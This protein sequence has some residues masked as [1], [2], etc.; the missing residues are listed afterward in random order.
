MYALFVLHIHVISVQL[1]YGLLYY[2]FSLCLFPIISGSSDDRSTLREPA[3]PSGR[4]GG[5]RNMHGY[6]FFRL[7]T[8]PY[9][10]WA[11]VHFTWSVLP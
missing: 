11:V 3:V 2:A 8:I 4:G 7:N 10:S 9:N 1:L 5:A 6:F